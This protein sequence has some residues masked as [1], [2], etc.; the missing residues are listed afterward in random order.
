MVGSRA[1]Q[2]P[3]PI[4]FRTKQHRQPKYIGLSCP[5]VNKGG[6]SITGGPAMRGKAKTQGGNVIFVAWFRHPATGK[7]IRAA[8]FGLKG[9]PIR[10][11][12][13]GRP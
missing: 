8:D 12:R 9:F 7:I 11:K 4:G 10:V 1:E 3:G 6:G 13:R 5:E 2:L